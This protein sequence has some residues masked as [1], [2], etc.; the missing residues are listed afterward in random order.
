MFLTV[1]FCGRHVCEQQQAGV[2][3]DAEEEDQ[4]AQQQLWQL[5][6]EAAAVEVEIRGGHQVSRR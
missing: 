5:L 6:D 4:P 3:G 1:C 2:L